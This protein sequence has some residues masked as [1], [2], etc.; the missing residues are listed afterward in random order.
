MEFNEKVV[1][2]GFGKVYAWALFIYGTSILIL[3]LIQSVMMT[4]K[5]AKSAQEKKVSPLV[6]TGILLA[7]PAI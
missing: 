6:Y 7:C 1:K 3:Q 4:Q 5:V 2:L